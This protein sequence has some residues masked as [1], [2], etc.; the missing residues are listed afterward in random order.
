MALHYAIPGKTDFTAGASWESGTAYASWATGDIVVFRPGY[1]YAYTTMPG[2]AVTIAGFE[3]TDCDLSFSSPLL[4][5]VST[6]GGRGILLRSMRRGAIQIGGATTSVTVIGPGSSLTLTTGAQGPLIASNGG[7]INV[8]AAATV[9][10]IVA[11]GSGTYVGVGSHASD[12]IATGRVAGGAKLMTR[13]SIETG[14]V[15][16]ATLRLEGAAG[17]TDG[18]TGGSVDLNDG[19]T[20]QLALTSAPTLKAVR[21]WNG[22]F[23]PRESELSITVDND[24]VTELA[25]F[26]TEYARGSVT[27]SATTKYGLV[28]ARGGIY[29]QPIIP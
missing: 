19:A 11:E 10:D 21:V 7:R 20:L 16:A 27:R 18:S 2:A 9:G 24:T 1:T 29:D 3:A 25:N 17:I 28:G 6:A 22:T 15:A 12:R 26:I 8:D 5:N 23:D 14:L 13:R 4:C